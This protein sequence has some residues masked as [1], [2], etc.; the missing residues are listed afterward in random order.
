[1]ARLRKV[2]VDEVE[3]TLTLE[4]EDT[5]IRGAFSSGDDEKDEALIKELT[6]RRNRGDDWAW[7]TVKVTAKWSSWTGCDYLGCCSYESEKDFRE[8]SGS[9]EDMKQRAVDDLNECVERAFRSV[10]PL[11]LEL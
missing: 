3:F 7:C 5:P 11:I 1:M 8:N 10:A 2:T 9:F 4:E 6:D